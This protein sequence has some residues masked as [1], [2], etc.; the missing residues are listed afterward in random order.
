MEEMKEGREED[1]DRGKRGRM[2]RG[3]WGGVR[4][5]GNRRGEEEEYVKTG[6]GLR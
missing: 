4:V 1:E 3:G 2:E 6:V 5:T